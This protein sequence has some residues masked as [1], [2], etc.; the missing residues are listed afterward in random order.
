MS[1]SL[2]RANLTALHLTDSCCQNLFHSMLRKTSR[3]TS[4]SLD[5][6]E[7]Q[8]FRSNGVRLAAQVARS[9]PTRG[10][11]SFGTFTV[12]PDGSIR[13]FLLQLHCRSARVAEQR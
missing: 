5:F 12:S 2:S 7:T 8:L 9:G 3:R 10:Y 13:Q 1:I 4:A 6:S 11:I